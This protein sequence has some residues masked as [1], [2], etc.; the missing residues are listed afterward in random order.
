MRDDWL[1]RLAAAIGALLVFTAATGLLLRVPPSHLGQRL[2]ADAGDPVLNLYFLEWGAKK[3]DEGLDGFWDANFYFPAAGVMTFADHLLGPAAQAALFR[4]I[5]DNGV[6]AYNFLFCS[7]FVLAGVV[8]AWVLRQAGASR[9]AALLA[10]LMFA[11][12]PYR[13]SQ[14]SHLP[15]L[16]AQWIPLVLW[17]WHR[18]L[19]APGWRPALAF[20]CFYVLHVTG[21]TY[22]AYLI[23]L[24]LAIVLAAHWRDWRALVAPR[25]LAVLLPTL[26]IAGGVAAAI[27][28]PY[29]EV[30]RRLGFERSP[31]E[32]RFFGATFGS[33][34]SAAN[35]MVW[36]WLRRF[37][38]PE[39]HLFAGLV[40][41][42][43]AATGALAMGREWRRRG[44]HRE[45]AGEGL[46]LAR[47]RQAP[48]DP[49][50][51]DRAVLAIGVFFFLLA[52]A[53]FYLPLS[54]TLPG[55]A[56]MRVP[57]RG[58]QFVSFA[59]VT[60]AAKGVD[61]LLVRMP[62]GS[63][64]ALVAAAIGVVLLF[65]LR[66][67]L[68]WRAWPP[69]RAD[70]GIFHEIQ[71]RPEVKAVL[72]LPILGDF[73]EAH[74]MYYSTL[75]WKPIANGY[76][77]YAPPIYLELR[78]RFEEHLLE[79]ET[80]DYLLDLGVTH[81]AIHPTLF[82]ERKPTGMMA[83]WEHH[84]SSEPEPRIRLVAQAGDD[85]LYELLRPPDSASRY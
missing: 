39:N 56:Q 23:H 25:S 1:R 20:T 33:W 73:H 12:S 27:F 4:R 67:R 44:A 8:T 14:R 6:A 50:V 47:D 75:H 81:V 22:L 76:S 59:L 62:R 5:W 40:T 85:R 54:R 36:G 84:F 71:R 7:S 16:L 19:A 43:F 37:G 26:L 58:Y 38:G 48:Q 42:G 29:L 69:P 45:A 31:T 55:L 82:R 9:A 77:G 18:L 11:F 10:G 80:V 41:T 72:H 21:G 2:P 79:D 64:R 78:R 53:W 30:H 34:F 46:T 15:V 52:F 74:Y 61:R 70:L 65:E 51:W 24:A 63:S 17:N 3:L 66:G 35:N 32:I 57:T 13:F 60:L 83:K 49:L 68:P 28:G